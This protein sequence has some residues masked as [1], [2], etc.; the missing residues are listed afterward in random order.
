VKRIVFYA[1]ALFALFVS[2]SL[3]GDGARA[4]DSITGAGN[5]AIVDLAGCTTNTLAAN[6]DESTP[7]VPI[8]FSLNFFGT[9]Y[10]TLNVN[11]NGNVTFDG[12]LD[13]FTPPPLVEQGGL[14]IIAPYFADVDTRAVGSGLTRYGATTFFGRPAFCVNWVNVGYYD[15]NLDKQNSFQLLLVDRSDIDPGDFDI[16]FNYNQVQWETGDHPSSGGSGGLGGHS[17]RAGYTNGVDTSLELPGSA[18]NGAFLDSTPSGLIHGSRGTT[19]HGRYIFPVRSGSAPSGG[20]V[21]G[22][23]LGD[24]GNG[25][26]EPLAGAA[27]QICRQDVV[28]AVCS[29]TTTDANGNYSVAGLPTGTY[30]GVAGPPA[31]RPDLFPDVND[32]FP[33]GNNQGLT[34]YDFKLLLPRPLPP[35]V[36][37]Q[38]ISTT[39]GG[40]PVINWAGPVQ[41]TKMND[42][43]QGGSGTFELIKDGDIIASGPMS[44]TATPGLF[45]GTIP[46]LRPQHGPAVLHIEVFCPGAGEDK[47]IEADVYIDPSGL[48]KT[49]DGTPIEGATVTLYRSDSGAGPFE[50]V[51]DGSA[52]MSPSNRTNPDLTDADG[53]FHW[54]VIVGFYKVRAEKSG[55]FNPSNP[56]QPFVETIVLEIPPPALDLDLRLQCGGVPGPTPTPPGGIEY[57]NVNCVGGVNSIDAAL[58]LQFSASL[59]ASLACQSAADVNE[60][61]VVNSIDAAIILQFISGL[62]DDLPV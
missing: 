36:T 43:C 15:T 30:N 28:P 49:P 48:V 45:K 5:K 58:V 34:D 32:L 60:D 39:S 37:I 44:A 11:N 61:G 10:S 6:D 16:I 2:F 59:V 54:D 57:G 19:Q 35:D 62:I 14:V 40:S 46:A 25:L 4:Q 8:G 17:A 47:D 52:I 9:S 29:A 3:L 20:F 41:V 24:S 12:P 55:C 23:V 18:V 51:P 7:A 53:F 27:V 21:S 13:A 1:I 33:L 31:D 22:R 56:G 26:N 38:G 50:V 42:N